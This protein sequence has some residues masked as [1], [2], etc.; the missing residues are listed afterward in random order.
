MLHLLLL[1]LLPDRQ[2]CYNRPINYLISN[3]MREDIDIKMFKERLEKELL[4]V[5]QELN[6]IGRKNPDN[7]LDWEAE[8]ADMNVDSAD[9]NETADNME[10]FEENTAVL[11]EL[12]IRY[13]DIK[14]ALAKIEKN[15]YGFCEVCQKPIEE[16][17]LLANQAARTCKE[18]MEQ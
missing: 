18:H 12:E 2:I 11:K 6:N 14:N 15:T 9:E 5:E 17:R 7:K 1:D 13:N 16:D 3:G 4:L 10:E 8:P